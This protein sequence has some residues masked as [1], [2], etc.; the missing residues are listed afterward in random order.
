MH[1]YS[2]VWVL[3]P[4]LTPTCLS[5]DWQVVEQRRTVTS[6]TFY[7]TFEWG[8]WFSGHLLYNDGNGYLLQAFSNGW[9]ETIECTE[10]GGGKRFWYEFSSKPMRRRLR[11]YLG[12]RGLAAVA[13]GAFVTQYCD[14][15]NE[16]GKIVCRI[17]W[18]CVA[19]EPGKDA[20][21][22]SC[23]V[24]P[25]RGYE[26]EALQVASRLAELGTTPSGPGPVS[27]LLQRSGH[28]PRV[29]TLKPAFALSF[30]TPAR[31]AVGRII[32]TILTIAES[33]RAG[34]MADLDTE[35]LHDYRICL[36]KAR[37]LLGL[38]KNVYPAGETER[39][40]NQLGELARA[41]NRLRD[42]DVYALTYY[43][44]LE[45]LP[46]PLHKG[47]ARIFSRFSAERKR[48]QRRISTHLQDHAGSSP[49][50]DIIAEISNVSGHA[51]SAAAFQQ[52]GPLVFK[53]ILKRYR[54]IKAIA[55]TITP[56]TS[57]E[58]L[59]Q[60]RIACKKLRYLMEFFNE[61][62]PPDESQLLQRQLR[63]LQGALG[64][65][66]D[67]SVQQEFLLGWWH[68]HQAATDSSLA[69]GG[70]L[71]LLHQRRKESRQQIDKMLKEF[72]DSSTAATFKRIFKLHVA[73]P[74]NSRKDRLQ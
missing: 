72:T 64:D 43:D 30:E 50:N 22:T 28:T 29:Y 13:A 61:L 27:L 16:S 18:S 12:L 38:V 7:D 32:A 5:A 11:T 24:L 66:N 49:L 35:F 14:L 59:H 34:I 56:E 41:T 36:R 45:N 74:K 62:F 1:E 39:F 9:P 6:C 8:L 21:F 65:F 60:L 40:R 3:P 58:T 46:T 2:A 10:Q 4:T 51:D 15:R 52:I 67:S 71:T 37:S 53:G 44:H 31:E 73:P 42:L 48:E 26:E 19:D 33:N 55:E 68:K 23:K 25:L 70:L 47:L 17:E 20:C 69:M 54:K 57:D 63:R